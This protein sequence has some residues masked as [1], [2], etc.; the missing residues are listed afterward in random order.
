MAEKVFA[1]IVLDLPQ[2]NKK[3]IRLDIKCKLDNDFDNDSKYLYG[4][5]WENRKEI[6]RQLQ[7]SG[8]TLTDVTKNVTKFPTAQEHQ[9]GWY[10]AIGIT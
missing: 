1:S 3:R 4:R 2:R 7:I 6:N 9:E 5:G 10:V 8:M